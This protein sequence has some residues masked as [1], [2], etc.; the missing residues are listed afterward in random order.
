MAQFIRRNKR[1]HLLGLLVPGLLLISCNQANSLRVELPPTPQLFGSLPWGMVNVTYTKGFSLPDTTSGVVAV[2]RGGDVVSILKRSQQQERQGALID[3]WYQVKMDDQVFWL[4]GNLLTFFG[5]EMQAKVAA[6]IL[7]DKLFNS[8]D[9][10]QPAGSSPSPD[11]G[12]GD[13]RG[14]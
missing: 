4:Y 8:E 2:L 1:F 13:S 10:N 5:L 11:R 6:S 3:Y 14:L 7:Q 9:L 12:N